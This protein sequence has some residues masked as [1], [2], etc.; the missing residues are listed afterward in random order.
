[1]LRFKA[2]NVSPFPFEWVDYEN[3]VEE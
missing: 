1:V 2:T 3:T